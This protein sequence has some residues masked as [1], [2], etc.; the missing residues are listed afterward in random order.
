[1]ST[2]KEVALVLSSG[3]PRGFAYIGAIEELLERGYTITSVAG[4][5]IGSLIGG[6][7]AAGKLP[8]FKKW[9]FSLD[10]WNLFSLMDLSFGKNHFV[11]GDRIIEAINQ[12]VPDVNIEDL[13]IPYKAIA[14][15]LYTG[16]EI[17]FDKG[18]LLPAIRASI[19]IPSLFRPV[20]HDMTSFIDGAMTNCLPLNRIDRKEGDILVAFDVNHIDINDIRE[21]LKKENAIEL[22]DAAFEEW[23]SSQ[24]KEIIDGMG[25]NS[26]NQSFMKRLKRAGIKGA[27]LLKEVMAH[28]ESM[29]LAEQENDTDFGETYYSILDRSF[30]ILYH[31]VTELSIQLNRPDILVRMPFDSYGE[32]ADYIKGAEISELGRNLMREALDK[33]ENI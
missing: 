14:T 4:T 33:Y 6:I 26:S 28:K 11:R 2:K 12:I 10:K 31:T 19:S 32:I 23:K 16:E 29:D 9:L 3:G 5:S 22:A 17:I 13:K 8:E 21:N 30:S 27:A 24:M 7:Y 18:K 20:K 1:M 15:D 25:S